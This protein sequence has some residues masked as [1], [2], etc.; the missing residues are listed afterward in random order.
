MSTAETKI[1]EILIKRKYITRK[2]LDH[3]LENQEDTPLGE[4]LIKMGYV[5]ENEISQALTQQSTIQTVREELSDAV[6]NPVQHKLLWFIVVF[7]LIGIGIIYNIVTGTVDQNIGANTSTNITQG[8]DI[9]ANTVKQKKLRLRYIGH[10]SRLKEMEDT[11]L[12]IKNRASLFKKNANSQMKGLES[13]LVYSQQIMNEQDSLNSSDI[14]DLEDI[15]F[16]FKSVQ[17]LKNRK[18]DSRDYDFLN[19]LNELEKKINALEARLPKED[20]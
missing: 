3:A 18:L 4:T 16:S 7:A 6:R 1:G 10:N 13:D 5:S 8:E 19:R 11:T 15:L 9:N 12:K 17:K 2:Q 20:K 14:G